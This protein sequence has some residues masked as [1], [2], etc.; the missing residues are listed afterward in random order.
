MATTILAILSGTPLWVWALLAG[1]TGLGL[2]ATRARRVK[3]RRVFATPL[4]FVGWG[5]ATLALHAGPT[6]L[7]AWPT[8][9]SLGLVLG[10]AVTRLDGVRGD[11][12]LGVVELPGSWLPLIRNL[13]IFGV[14]Y[15][16]AVAAALLPAAH[17]RLM[18]WDLAV[19]GLSA[20]YFAG[21]L[22]VFMRRWRHTP[23]AP[24][25]AGVVVPR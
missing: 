8:A 15:A 10:L 6:A 25:A 4:A 24:R 17:D 19:S 21:W 2:Q 18:L 12:A 11:R 16:L 1:L 3:L 22:A 9:A 7:V 14:R 13:G 5:L 23:S 20:G